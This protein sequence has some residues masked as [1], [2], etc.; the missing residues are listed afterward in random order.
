MRH[1]FSGAAVPS[2]SVRAVE[3]ECPYPGLSFFDA[4]AEDYFFGRSELVADARAR[5]THRAAGL[6][7]LVVVGASGAGKSSVLRAGVLPATRRG[8]LRDV[9][10][11]GSPQITLVPTE[12]PLVELLARVTK[13]LGS[14]A[15]A[16]DADADAVRA[17]PARFAATLVDLL[18]A[19]P[20]TA[21][22]GA[23]PTPRRLLLAVD[24]FEEVFTLCA[25]EVERAAFIRALCAA[26]TGPSAP[27]VVV[28]VVRGDFYLRCT[29]YPELAEAL[30][31]GQLV[32]G[33]MELAEVR[34][35]IV[36]PAR[37]AGGDVEPA[38]VDLLL[39]DLAEAGGPAGAGPQAGGSRADVGALPLLAHVLRATWTLRTGQTL[40][41]ASYR[42]AGRLAGALAK[43]AEDLFAALDDAGRAAV[44]ELLPRLARVGAAGQV[45]RRPLRREALL[46]EVGGSR[47][48]AQAALD[49]L[50]AARL[51]EADEDRV[52]IVHE[53]L[54]RAW[55]RLREWIERDRAT[56]LVRQELDERAEE[57]E[58]HGGDP[59]FLFSGLRL[60]AARAQLE[61]QGQGQGRGQGQTGPRA[62]PDGRGLSPR[63]RRFF[64]ACVAREHAAAVATRRRTRRLRALAA[65]LAALLVLAV[66]LTGLFV[67]QRSAAA[68]LHDRARSQFVAG[69]AQDQAS[70]RTEIGA[71]LALV[72]RGFADTSEA[73]SAILGAR[74][75]TRLRDAHTGPIPAVAYSRDG[76]LLATG[77]EDATVALWEGATPQNGL[78]SRLPA[79]RGA[80]GKPYRVGSV[81]FSR[82][83]HVLAVGTA[84]GVVRLWDVTDPARPVPGTAL[85]TASADP[86]TGAVG[87]AF[88][89]TADLLAV[90]G[91]GATVLLFD[92][93]YPATPRPLKALGDIADGLR[94][95][96]AARDVTFSPDGTMIITGG[97]DARAILW[98][99]PDR[100]TATPARPITELL[101]PD[102]PAPVPG[103]R[104]PVAFS[105]DGTTVYR[106]SVA[107]VDYFRLTSAG[108]APEYRGF[109]LRRNVPY[110]NHL[111][112][113]AGGALA[114][115][116]D[117]SEIDIYY[118]GWGRDPHVTLPLPRGGL[119]LAAS[120]DGRRLAS[121]TADG[122]LRVH[123]WDGVLPNDGLPG[124][125]AV[126][127]GGP[128]DTV[129][130]SSMLDI[131][132]FRADPT[133]RHAI[134]LLGWVDNAHPFDATPEELALGVGGFET[135]G[136]EL[137]SRDQVLIS[138]SA[139]GFSLWDVSPR[140]LARWSR[141]PSDGADVLQNG[142]SRVQRRPSPLASVRT[143][144]SAR[145]GAARRFMSMDLSPDGSLLA[146]GDNRGGIDLWDVS[147][148]RHPVHVGER[149]TAHADTNDVLVAFSA[150]GGLLAS[151][152]ND[153]KVRLWNPADLDAGLL[154]EGGFG[155]HPG[156]LEFSPTG[157]VLAVGGADRRVYLVD[158]AD[159]AA[160]RQLGRTPPARDPIQAVAFSP[161]GGRLA[162]GG[163]DVK[164]WDVA[165]TAAAAADPA[166]I[167]ILPVGPQVRGLAFSAD[168]R[169]VLPAG[170]DLLSTSWTP[171]DP[172]EVARQLC[173]QRGDPISAVEW[174][175][176]LPDIAYRDPCR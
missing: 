24:Q 95:T 132:A 124:I 19:A 93:R 103:V 116:S 2:D 114:V 74:G 26:A 14:T 38:L 117:Y 45:T 101:S 175:Q 28:L 70:G 165:A 153:Q 108:A 22:G 173:G 89:P 47:A 29:A 113:L 96:A 11:P 105:L 63:A 60:S 67:D 68:T 40:R 134:E 100:S 1:D 71:Q 46:D 59:S 42:Q 4:A 20:S 94:H 56:A 54:L 32:V 115:V 84:D 143:G 97:L 7:P 76:A 176:Y 154:G 31:H 135:L 174:A 80:D 13:A 152:G 146:V 118:P 8:G 168:G 91:Y 155:G 88:S 121:G 136:L 110:F 107:K 33:T 147:D 111:V 90:G 170:A 129:F 65:G 50:I 34:E 27:A 167:A 160:M 127:P 158:V 156:D 125:V 72:A 53:A 83:G 49:R 69:L 112:A 122:D 172:D 87:L 149:R 130:M 18:A 79:Y 144:E 171:V 138:A 131:M 37:M 3:P 21:T 128:A 43:T 58:R 30:Q 169:Y 15:T 73:R 139:E 82:D 133:G 51:V 41:V 92:V 164:L 137:R 78:I 142:S 163:G 77:G 109:T 140:A 119:A 150:D 120:P 157:P 16:P 151:S 17:E 10:P 162:A 12:R 86:R 148:P 106:A 6:G 99:A 75:S 39:D 85:P 57:W 61:G 23:G 66:S 36:E 98:A 62:Q 141:E 35:A 44:R 9:L 123:R 5:L 55:P 64:D 166:L 159:P 104:T 161:D 126:E 102:L 52:Q 25:D 48:E 81:A 145:D